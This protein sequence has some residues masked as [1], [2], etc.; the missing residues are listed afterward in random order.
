MPTLARLPS[1]PL[2]AMGAA[3]ADLAPWDGPSSAS[4][5]TP[6]VHR[7]LVV[8]DDVMMR[9]LL[10]L[11]LEKNGYETVQA[12]D[13]AQALAA[14]TDAV[15]DVIIT[16]LDMPGID[17]IAF[18]R[19]VQRRVAMPVHIIILTG[20]PGHVVPGL[21]AGAA[22]YMHKPFVAGELL[23]R[24]AAGVRIVEKQKSL[25]ATA[26]S[27]RE[28]WGEIRVEQQRV[29]QELTAAA[30]L[31]SAL[32]PPP[33]ARIE[34]IDIAC[35]V[36]ATSILSGDMVGCFG[37][38][39]GKASIFSLDVSGHGAPAALLATLM[40]HEIRTIASSQSAGRE[41]SISR[42]VHEADDF[43]GKLNSKFL[44]WANS[45]RYSTLAIATVDRMA[46]KAEIGVA[47]HPRPAIIKADGSVA[48]VGDGG[49][50]IGMLAN[51]TYRSMHVELARGERLVLF[52]D[53][54]L[55]SRL[56]GGDCLGYDGMA[57]LLRSVA[58]LEMAHVAEAMVQT[59][60]RATRRDA[61]DDISIIVASYS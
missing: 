26:S 56:P 18:C 59:V 51:A 40:T 29:E 32:L 14:V 1:R 25:L 38:T 27:L 11:V 45:D 17:G 39:P 44:D 6:Q 50:P 30:A 20:H 35:S 37:G 13:A 52:T 58:M 10:T 23:A 4:C 15:P 3:P 33:L 36:E 53:G 34:G 47:G 8:D 41:K 5:G 16:D 19:L 12:V 28:S 2:Q 46:G 42:R 48:F 49:Y 61:S 43:L 31:Q 55:E 24:V 21:E 54:F 57:Q 22:D 60:R 7:V 9:R